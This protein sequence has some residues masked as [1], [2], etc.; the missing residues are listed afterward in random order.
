MDWRGQAT[1]AIASALADAWSV[2][3]ARARAAATILAFHRVRRDAERCLDTSMQITPEYLDAIVRFAL[4]RDYDIVSMDTLHSRLSRREFT[5][6]MV[7]ITFDDG[8]R[9]NAL[10]AA[11]VLARHGVPWTL[12]LAT[13]FAD[14]S[15]DYWWGALEQ[16]VRERDEI[17]IDLPGL[18]CRFE[19]ISLTQKRAAIAGIAR[20]ARLHSKALSAQLAQRYGVSGADLLDS[21]ALSWREVCELAGD[22]NVTLGGHTISHQSMTALEPAEAWHEI[23]GCRERI[24]QMTGREVVHFAPPHGTPDTWNQ[25]HCKMVRDAGYLTMTTTQPLSIFASDRPDMYRLPRFS[26]QGNQESLG[27]IGCKLAGLT[28][29]LTKARAGTAKAR[30]E[31]SARIDRGADSGRSVLARGRSY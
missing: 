17:E 13:G 7:A 8:Y 28:T 31:K 12:Y 1:A 18:H 27:H 19:T 14:R 23:S 15:C 21:E 20:H 29:L 3:P 2:A 6:P 30:D 4:S 9:D 5:R 24:E 10:L 26:V 25:E 16:A 11:P 22:P